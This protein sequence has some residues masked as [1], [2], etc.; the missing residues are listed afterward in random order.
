MRCSIPT[1]TGP[2]SPSSETRARQSHGSGDRNRRRYGSA[3]AN[4]GAFR[5]VPP[6]QAG[7]R[8]AGF[9]FCEILLRGDRTVSYLSLTDADREAMLGA[10]GVASLDELFEQIPEGV[11]FERELDVPPALPEAELVRVFAELAARNA[12][13]GARAQ[14]PRHGDL[15]PLRAVARRRLPRPRRAPHGLHAVPARDEPGRAPGDLRVPDRRLRADGDGR[16]ERLGLRRDDGRRRRLLHR[17]RPHRPRADRPRGDPPPDG[18]AGREDLRAR[19]RDGGRRGRPRRRHDR[20]R[21]V[22]G[23][24]RRRRDRDLPAPERLRVPRARAGARGGGERGRRAARGARRPRLARRA[25]GAGRLRLRDGDRRRPVDRQLPE[26]RRP[27][28]R[29][30]RRAP[31][32]HPPDA[33]A[34]RR[35][36]DRPRGP[37]AASCSRSRR[38]SS[39]SAA[40][41]RPRTSR[42]TRRCSRSRA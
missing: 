7:D 10:I 30:P 36:D 34:D 35:R 32:V 4:A 18:A 25:R 21:A 27:A 17:A 22:R 33:R 16:L 38:A 23:G 28:L 29:L 41:R 26:L 37:S 42:R 8:A 5:G 15:R 39:T 2:T 9:R 12:D 11:R 1:P 3:P 14:L 6:P 31:G 40:R 20:S 24:G 13:T 19:I